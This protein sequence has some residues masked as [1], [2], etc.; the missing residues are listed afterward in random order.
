[1]PPA[2][3]GPTDE[4]LRHAIDQIPRGADTGRNNRWVPATIVAAA[5]VLIVAGA[6]SPHR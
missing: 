6:M 5:V 3:S 4:E 2:T 1:M